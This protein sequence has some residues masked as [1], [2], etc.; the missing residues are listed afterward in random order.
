MDFR[1]WRSSLRLRDAC[2]ELL[3]SPDASVSLIARRVGFTDRSNFT[4]QFKAAFGL[5]PD[6]W[7]KKSKNNLDI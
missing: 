4:R 5:T 6:S 3:D 7:R 2:Q 1:S